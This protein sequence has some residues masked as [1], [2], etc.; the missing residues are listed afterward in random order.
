MSDEQS[1]TVKAAATA[2]VALLALGWGGACSVPAGGPG[3][4]AGLGG[5]S[6][7]GAAGSG[8]AAGSTGS[9]GAAGGAGE[10]GNAGADAAADAGGVP[11]PGACSKAPT[12]A[13]GAT[14]IDVRAPATLAGALATA[15]AGDRIVLHAGSYANE[16]TRTASSRRPCSSRRPRA[17]R[18]RWRARLHELR[19]TCRS[20]ASSSRPRSCSTVEQLRLP[21][22]HPGRR[23]HRGGRAADPRAGRR[24]RLARRSGRG[25]DDQAAAAARSSSSASSRPPTPGTTTSP[26]CATTSPAARTTASRSRAGATW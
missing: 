4:A 10:S 7:T 18:S 1:M 21:R 8:A 2:V 22:R 24:G 5:A 11:N 13:A 17:R 20:A 25:L 6:S 3:G 23:R 15:K 19:T 9:A 12:P 26:S 16:K 14:V